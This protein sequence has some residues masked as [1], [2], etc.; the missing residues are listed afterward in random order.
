M[1]TAVG[2]PCVLGAAATSAAGGGTA[3]SA[4]LHD[5]RRSPKPK[6]ASPAVVPGPPLLTLDCGPFD[7]T[8]SVAEALAEVYSPAVLRL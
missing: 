2:L 3:D 8:K 1:P 7:I 6:N 4:Q 5:A